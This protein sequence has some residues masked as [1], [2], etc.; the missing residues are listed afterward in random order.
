MSE[1]TS[2]SGR[3][4]LPDAP[5]L[6]WLRKQAKRRLDDIRKKNP[7]AKLADAQLDLAR[8]YG[9][10]SWRA[11]KAHVDSLTIDGQLFDAAR[12]G[13]V[14]KLRRLIDAHPEKLHVRDKPYEHTLLHIAA[15]NG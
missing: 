1:P 5:N 7:D 6:D 11:L 15:H 12:T 10:A 2:A 8:R 14:E 13:E 9:F 3:L 4:A